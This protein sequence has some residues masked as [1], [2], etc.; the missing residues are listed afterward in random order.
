[1]QY[2]GF[3]FAGS[4]ASPRRSSLAA[5]A[6]DGIT[7]PLAGLDKDV[8]LKMVGMLGSLLHHYEAAA[9]GAG[10]DVSDG[11]GGLRTPSS[12]Q[13][14]PLHTGVSVVESTAISP[15]GALTPRC[16]VCGGVR[17]L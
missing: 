7:A 4:L 16:S 6:A 3:C 5:S 17:C 10:A 12:K 14:S 11:D 9:A 1:M 8:L 13:L 2:G 15:S